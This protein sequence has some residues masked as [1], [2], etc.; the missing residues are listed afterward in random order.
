MKRILTALISAITLFSTPIRA[1]PDESTVEKWGYLPHYAK[2]SDDDLNRYIEDFD[3]ICFTGILINKDCRVSMKKN[4]LTDK[5]LSHHRNRRANLYPLISFNS[6]TTGI[7]ILAKDI[8][9]KKT[10]R[11][12]CK[13]SRT[14]NFRGIH[15]DIERIPARY[16]PGIVLFIKILH[17]SLK[18]T[19]LTMALYPQTDYRR[20]YSLSHDI[21]LLS[22]YLERAVIMCYDLHDPTTDAGPVTDL[23][24]AE[25]NINYF[26]N[27]MPRNRI[28]L[29]IPAYGYLWQKNKK[30]K[31]VSSRYAGRLKKKYRS[32]RHQSGTLEIEGSGNNKFKAFVSDNF[33]RSALKNLA[34]EQKT[35]GWAVWRLGFE[36]D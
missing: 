21:R 34:K 25:K 11:A 14:H 17:Q 20:Q 19:K 4:R 27:F 28:I 12:L 26:K 16:S 30:T 2:I 3:V 13:F 31:A 29:G 9:I 7:K 10:V 24:W 15:L 23:L 6:P 33:C 36:E 5:I 18:K 32:K 35:A 8:L 1:V 22:P